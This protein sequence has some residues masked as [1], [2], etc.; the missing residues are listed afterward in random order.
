MHQGQCS[1]KTKTQMPDEISPAD[2]STW[3]WRWCAWS[4]QETFFYFRAVRGQ[5]RKSQLASF[6]IKRMLETATE[7]VDRAGFAGGRRRRACRA[8]FSS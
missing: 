5:D 2:L 1:L 7:F 8:D 4:R 6:L 3:H